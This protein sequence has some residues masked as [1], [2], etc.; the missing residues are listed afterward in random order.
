[1]CSQFVMTEWHIFSW[2]QFHLSLEMITLPFSPFILMPIMNYK[3]K[4]SFVENFGVCDNLGVSANLHILN[5]G[6]TPKE[7]IA[8]EKF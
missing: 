8:P 4:A 1:M 3:R 2:I 6:L 7:L 5:Y